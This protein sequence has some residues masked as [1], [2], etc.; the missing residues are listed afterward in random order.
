MDNFSPDAPAWSDSCSQ[1]RHQRPAQPQGQRPPDNAGTGQGICTSHLFGSTSPCGAAKDE[2]K[3]REAPGGA[4]V[5][6]PHVCPSL[7]QAEAVAVEMD[8]IGHSIGRGFSI[9]H[10]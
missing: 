5:P 8:P 4:A 6:S 10:F 2:D 9:L 7:G 1:P 3:A